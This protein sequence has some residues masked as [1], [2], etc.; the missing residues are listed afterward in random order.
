MKIQTPTEPAP[1]RKDPKTDFTAE[2][3]PPP[4]H[5]AGTVPAAAT[6]APRRRRAPTPPRP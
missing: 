5:V 3:S 4:G 2:G 6:P 1:T